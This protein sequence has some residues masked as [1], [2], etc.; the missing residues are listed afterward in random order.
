MGTSSSYPGPTGPNP[1]LPPWADPIPPDEPPVSEPFDEPGEPNENNENPDSDVS[2]PDQNP[3]KPPVSWS[4]PKRHVGRMADGKST[5]SP[6]S[7]A[8]SYVRASGGARTA[9]T[10]ATS[11]R[12]TTSRLGGFFADAA[13]IGFVEAARRLGVGDLIG[14]DVQYVLASLVDLI[15][16]DGALREEAAARKA[17][18]ET[19]SDIFERF[20]VED[21]GFESL[22]TIGVEGMAEIVELSVTNYINER[23]QQELVFRIEQ[24]TLAEAEANSVCEELRDFISGIVKLDFKGVDLLTMDWNTDG[25]RL[26]DNIYVT[27]YSL[28]EEAS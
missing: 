14:R 1:L 26:I 16:P 12:S 22:D 19:M 3:V 27:A 2:S 10:A 24:G 25:K 5:A 18:I 8:R 6:R 7:T 15:A 4:S 28:I 20:D 11:G 23:M 9:A 13:R 21:N 17:L